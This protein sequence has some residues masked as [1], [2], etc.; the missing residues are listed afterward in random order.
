MLIIGWGSAAYELR[1]DFTRGSAPMRAYGF[2]QV[3]TFTFHG[4]GESRPLATRAAW[5][6]PHC[7]GED[8]RIILAAVQKARSKHREQKEHCQGSKASWRK[9]FLLE[10]Q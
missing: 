2:P 6:G 3:R 5:V 4:D 7:E 10:K 9:R 8:P 1:H